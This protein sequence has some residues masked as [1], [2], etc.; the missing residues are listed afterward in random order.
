MYERGM[1]SRQIGEAV[2]IPYRT[3]LRYLRKAG[4][5]LRNP[6]AQHYHQLDDAEWL[7]KKY[8]DEKLSSSKIA[9]IIGCGD[10]TV[11]TWIVRHGIPT[12]DCGA[13]KG[14]K[15]FTKEARENLSRAKRGKYTGKSNPNWR[16]GTPSRDPE[17]N[18]FPAKEWSKAVRRRDKVCQECGASDRL[19]AHH[20]KRWRDY[21]EL[22][23][24]LSNGIT[25]C[26]ACHE[27]AHGRG[28]K[29]RWYQ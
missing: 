22:R 11:H 12:R 8:L 16:G 15:R 27:R 19:H 13:E 26:H 28:F 2:D 5:K 18:R 24:E 20:I 17:R 10:K 21:P 23:Y 7:R 25:L 9:E 4:A 1:T 14:H 6:G 3:I 29:F